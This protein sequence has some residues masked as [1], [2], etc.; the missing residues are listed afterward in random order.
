MEVF[1]LKKI[2]TFGFYKSTS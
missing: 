2:F 1:F